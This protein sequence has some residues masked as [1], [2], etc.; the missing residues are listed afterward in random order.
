M[1]NV[2]YRGVTLLSI[3]CVLVSKEWHYSVAKATGSRP[4]VAC[5]QICPRWGSLPSTMNRCC[6]QYYSQSAV[7]VC[8]ERTCLDP[9]L[10]G[11]PIIPI[12]LYSI[13]SLRAT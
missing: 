1:M 13:D 2:R 5:R 12:Q 9:P 7:W 8:S 11:V 4:L 3:V 10:L 6:T